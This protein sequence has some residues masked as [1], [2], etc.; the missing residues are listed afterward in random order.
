MRQVWNLAAAGLTAIALLGAPALAQA[1]ATPQPGVTPAAA[2]NELIIRYASGTTA[3][4]RADAR[5]DAGADFA[6]GTRLA[7]TEVVSVD[8]SL[9]AA[10]TRLE[11]QPDVRFAV[12]NYVLHATAAAPNDPRFA[13]Q[14]G[15][16]PGGASAGGVGVL[17]A[18]DV[19]RGAGQTVAVLDT[20]IDLTHPDLLPS[21]WTNPGEIPGNRVDDDG[22]GKVD[23]VHGWD[24]VANDGVPDDYAQHG[25]HVAGIVAAAAGNAL[26]G[27]G[28]AP[29]AKLMSV[30]VL[31][32]DGDGTLDRIVAGMVYAA[33][34]GA[35]VINLSLGGRAPAGREAAVARLWS[36][37]VAAAG[38]RGAVVVAAAGND[39][40]DNDAIPDYPCSA[41]GANLICVA[42]LNS[43]GRFDTSYSNYG[44]ASVD[45]GAP[46]TLVLS[47]VPA[48][49][50]IFADSFDSTANWSLSG[51]WGLFT[52]S[53]NPSL[54]DSPSGNYAD[55][56]VTDARTTSTV[57]T[58]TDLGCR[59]SFAAASVLASG[60][61]ALVGVLPDGSST[62]TVAQS[63]TSS[64]NSTALRFYDDSIEAAGGT[65]ARVY[66]KLVSNASGTADGIRI[67]DVAVRCRTT[68]HAADSTTDYGLLSGTSM[69]APHVA[70]V[71]ALVRAAA[72]SAS[73][74]LVVAAIKA[75]SVPV[76]TL[77]GRTV[78]GGRVDALGAI[79]ALVAGP[80]LEEPPPGPD[81]QPDPPPAPVQPIV[82]P[83]APLGPT[84]QQMEPP[85]RSACHGKH[86]AALT[87]CKLDQSVRTKCAM[88]KGAGYRTCAK[89]VRALAHCRALPAKTRGQRVKK[90]QC[91]AKAHAIG[92]KPSASARAKQR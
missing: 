76:A 87:R 24:F 1:Q 15:L 81:P 53:G 7:D 22:N 35:T 13:S 82:V 40:A 71:A 62:P 19:T 18:W 85:A 90:Q 34:E 75:G 45:V 60:D 89:K 36:D 88:L 51:T 11:R 54:A 74:A 59:L 31:D 92:R 29:A 26:G 17:A 21:L 66:A 56:T 39:R 57:T 64:T 63:F 65:S 84:V 72:P 52:G 61:T 48:Y 14:W 58:R 83:P 28:V 67:D 10:A 33:Q 42:A 6:R 80:P 47:S 32:G 38:A 27:A 3:P 86:G 4:E 5:S 20:G 43:A 68:V 50:T 30:R 23:D 37:A 49:R 44:A 79:R 70:G 41:T 12:P 16:Q 73:P 91:A 46:G 55:N 25:T 69:A 8:G 77:A 2:P 9:A 78:T